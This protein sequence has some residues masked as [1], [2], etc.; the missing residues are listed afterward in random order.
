MA[1]R[2]DAIRWIADDTLVPG[3]TRPD[4]IPS[5]AHPDH[6]LWRNGRLWWVAFTIHRGHRQERVRRSL[7]TDDCVEARSAR[8]ALLARFRA[9]PAVTV[10]L[11]FAPRAGRI[12]L[13]GDQE[14]A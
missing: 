8:D 4:G 12:L 2:E 1:R 5:D 9:D 6:H 14:V 7:G 10:S 13:S 11:R 3:S